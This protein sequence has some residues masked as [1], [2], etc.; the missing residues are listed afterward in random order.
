MHSPWY[1]NHLQYQYLITMIAHLLLCLMVVEV[2]EA[3][4][5]SGASIQ[6]LS[7]PVLVLVLNIDTVMGT[8]SHQSQVAGNPTSHLLDMVRS[9]Q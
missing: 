5:T 7:A 4:N 3:N 9:R 1:T 6:W 2:G 8:T